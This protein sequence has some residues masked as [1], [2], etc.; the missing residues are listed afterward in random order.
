[1]REGVTAP[2]VDVQLPR[3]YGPAVYLWLIIYG[4]ISAGLALLYVTF[5]YSGGSDLVGAIQRGDG[6]SS[7]DLTPIPSW[8]HSTPVVQ[9]TT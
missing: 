9:D 1:M 3:L 6:N 8:H 4:S 7:K 5:V 2:W